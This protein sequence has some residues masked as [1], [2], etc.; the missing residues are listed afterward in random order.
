MSE[1]IDYVVWLENRVKMLEAR[2]KDLELWMR[3]HDVCLKCG[4]SEGSR[5]HQCADNSVFR[6]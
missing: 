5:P 6:G 4:A 3:F 1:E 2:V